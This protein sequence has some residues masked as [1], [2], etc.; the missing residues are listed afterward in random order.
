MKLK[1]AVADFVRTVR[2]ICGIFEFCVQKLLCGVCLS[3]DGISLHID[4]V[5]PVD[6]IISAYGF[7]QQ[8]MALIV[9]KPTTTPTTGDLGRGSRFIT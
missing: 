2:R 3:R 1:K 7:A 4:E 8:L 5:E 6:G 9:E